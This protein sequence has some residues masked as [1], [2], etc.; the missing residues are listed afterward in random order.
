MM[1]T[2]IN[3]ARFSSIV[4]MICCLSPLSDFLGLLCPLVPRERRKPRQACACSGDRASSHPCREPTMPSIAARYAAEPVLEARRADARVVAG[5]EGLIVQLRAEVARVDI[6]DHLAGVL[7]R[8]QESS[9]RVRR[10][11]P[12]RGRP[13][14]PCRSPAPRAR[15]RPVRRRRHPT[16][17]AAPGQATGEPSCPS[18]PDWAMPPMNSKNCVERRIV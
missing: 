4:F 17:W 16:R 12:A 14:R 6:C 18:V 2:T 15:R 10:G 7:V 3:M 9:G 11:G 1:N 13:S 5:G 8:A